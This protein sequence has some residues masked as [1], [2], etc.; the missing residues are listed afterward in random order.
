M[1]TL[2][3]PL[4]ERPCN[5]LYPQY[6]AETAD[7]ELITPAMGFLSDKKRAADTN[8]LWQ[9]MFEHIENVNN[10]VLSMDMMMYGGLIPSRLHY[11]SEADVVSFESNLR[12]LKSINPSAKIYAY[13]CIMRC[14]SYSSSD[15][16][17]DYY[18][19]Y[20]A[21]IF[22]GKYLQDKS[23]R[24]SLSEQEAQELSNLKGAVPNSVISDFETRRGFNSQVNLLVAQLV[25]EK[26][27][28]FLVIPQDDS[29]PFGYTAIDQQKV[30]AY[31]DKES[32]SFDIAIYPGADEVGV[33]LL[34]RAFNEYKNRK[35]KI[36]PFYASTLGPQIVPLYED[37]PMNESVKSHIRAA[38]GVWC[39][40][41]QD[42]DFI[43]AINSPGKFMQ[44]AAKQNEKDL[45]YSSGRN[46]ADFALRISEYIESGKPVMVADSAFANGGDIELV[47]FLDKLQVLGKLTSYK[48]WN[49]NCNTLG[50]TLGA[51]MIA[52][53]DNA[54]R[55][56]NICFHVLE[57]VC[58]QSVVRSQLLNRYF[59]QASFG[60]TNYAPEQIDEAMQF[61]KDALLSQYSKITARSL[62]QNIE[63]EAFSPWQ[64]TFEI[65]LK[66]KVLQNA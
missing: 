5:Y 39:D 3:I 50:T 41:G 33:T 60:H 42:A 24:E 40:N 22:R 52:E 13:N 44:E 18:D 30:I 21:E 25:K 36:Y 46:L 14:P 48:G 47:S 49:T 51:G 8:A 2:F 31:I 45:T 43:L 26:V 37:R 10:V 63:L 62:P 32:L 27:V 61:A 65:G 54:A 15:E 38:G 58:Y 1:K 19:E 29:S 28:D 53:L 16:E 55:V 56:K 9:F 6:I 11:L 34:S 59:S 12:K 4:D 64:R 20:G 23:E 17:P 35:P 57:D 7:I 66:L